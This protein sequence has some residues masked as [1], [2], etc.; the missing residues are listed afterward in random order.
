MTG[1]ARGEAKGLGITK[2]MVSA[3]ALGDL[4]EAVLGNFGP[5]DGGASGS[6]CGG[7]GGCSIVNFFSRL[8]RSVVASSSSIVVTAM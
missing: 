1:F 5:G 2:E 4:G 7:G 8:R 6:D 3:S